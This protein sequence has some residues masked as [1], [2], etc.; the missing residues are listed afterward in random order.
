MAEQ[1]KQGWIG[2]QALK[3]GGP[4]YDEFQVVGNQIADETVKE[5][6]LDPELVRKL[7]ISDQDLVTAMELLL[8][9]VG[10]LGDTLTMILS[11]L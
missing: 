1:T 2:T 8:E 10:Q 6:N 3:R 4:G 5:V 9:E 7:N 11:K